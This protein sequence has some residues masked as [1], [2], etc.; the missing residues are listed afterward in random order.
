MNEDQSASSEGDSARWVITEDALAIQSEDGTTLIPTAEQVY[1]WVFENRRD[2]V[3]PASLCAPPQARLTFSRYPLTLELL[4]VPRG[5]SSGLRLTV[6]AHSGQVAFTMD[7]PLARQADHIVHDGR[8]YPF[9]PGALA[10]IKALATEASVTDSSE[11][12]LRQYLKLIELS[13]SHPQIRDESG[14]AARSLGRNALSDLRAPAGF[15]GTLYPY[16]KEGLRW[17]RFISSQDV[18]GILADEMG[19]GKTVQIAALLVSELTSHLSPSL[20]IG[21]G[22]LLE[23][24]RRELGKFVPGLRVTLHRGSDRTGF[25]E[26]LSQ[27]HVVIS[28]YDT[29]VRDISLLRQIQWNFV[30]L[31][32]AQAIKNPDTQ[33]AMTIKR[34][35]RRVGLAVTGTPVENSLA[36]M[37]S[38]ADFVLPGFLGSRRAFDAQYQDDETGA[39]LLEPLVSP[40][41]LRRRVSEVASDLPERIDIPQGLELT[42]EQA[43]TYEELRHS[44]IDEHGPNAALVALTKLRMFC[45][46]ERLIHDHGD[47][48]AVT[49]TKYQRL[50]EILEE[51]T[52]KHE[53][54]LIFTSYNQMADILM[55]DLPRRFGVWVDFI[56]GRT[57]ISE[58]QE[59]VDRF[60]AAKGAAVLILNPRAAG[61]GLNIAAA[62]HVVH[63]NLEWNPA[64]EDQ[65]S[66]RAYRRGQDLPVTVHRL[67]Y[68][69]TV[70]ETIDE[71]VSR[72]R[73]VA[74]AAVV[75]TD[76]S[77]ES[78]SDIAAALA[79]TPARSPS[80]VDR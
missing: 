32:E 36:D 21:P 13:R 20:V 40:V 38:I 73:L 9:A 16:Q 30:V 49:S 3:L 44:I 15:V 8:W 34:I 68:V 11:L 60:G 62:N 17:L 25:P 79:R 10:E 4:I 51:T 28:S 47:D 46:H 39:A 35:P 27:Y 65:A 33:R 7:D 67:F 41:L 66:A 14:G 26:E 58:R 50:V 29:A 5:K 59:V 12:K 23:N 55:E 42:E 74:G 6:R 70:E 61:T 80:S 53:K 48:P 56:D 37:W 18:G 77:D 64:V 45:A 2:N 71:R 57:P 24:W 52:A 76:G 63:Y 22:T 31:D 1:A 19:L 69:D 54:T 78:L 72:K 43:T 75:G